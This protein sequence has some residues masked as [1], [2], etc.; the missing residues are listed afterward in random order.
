MPTPFL[1]GHAARVADDFGACGVRQNGHTPLHCSSPAANSNRPQ[2]LLRHGADKKLKINGGEKPVHIV[3][4]AAATSCRSRGGAIT[5][6]M[7]QLVLTLLPLTLS[8]SRPLAATRRR[9][10]A[11]RPQPLRRRER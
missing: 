2:L 3:A 8:P 4:T 9:A 10:R 5:G 7:A 1:R 6:D 11:P